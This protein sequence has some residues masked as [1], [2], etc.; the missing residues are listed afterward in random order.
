MDL[1][2]KAGKRRQ[3]WIGE[4]GWALHYTEPMLGSLSLENA[5][6]MG[7]MLLLGRSVPGVRKIFKHTGVPWNEGG[8]L[9]AL[10]RAVTTQCTRRRQPVRT[11]P[12]RESCTTSN[13]PGNSN[14]PRPC[15]PSDPTNPNATGSFWPCGRATGGFDCTAA[16]PHRRERSILSAAS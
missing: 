9:Y 13:R 14:S 2:E 1:L 15:G 3:M 12:A 5:G 11:R 4:L 7:Q 6:G 16:C 10:F 8:H